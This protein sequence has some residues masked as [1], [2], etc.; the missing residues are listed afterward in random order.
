MLSKNLVE[1]K[2]IQKSYFNK[3]IIKGID[4]NLEEG[5]FYCLLGRNGTGK[6]TL[7]RIIAGIE[8]PQ[9]GEGHVLG[10][11]LYEFG[12]NIYKNFAY[13]S[14]DMEFNIG[15]LSLFFEVYK[16]CY[17]Q[18]DLRLLYQ[19]LKEFQIN[20]EKKFMDLSR[21]QKMQVVLL[22]SICR[23]P[24][25]ILIDEATAVLDLF[26]KEKLLHD[27][28]ELVKRNGATVLIVSN[29]VGE[30]EGYV[31]EAI[32]LDNGQIKKI[33]KI[34]ELKNGCYKIRVPLKKLKS[35]FD[36]GYVPV[37]RDGEGMATFLIPKTKLPGEHLKLIDQYKDHRSVSLEEFYLLICQENKS[38]E[39]VA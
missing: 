32:F 15:S 28:H 29:V 17:P 30:L 36:L 31:D 37:K 9:E 8:V 21:G 23:Q 3:K 38:E 19:K 5:K 7:S 6:S 16:E 25:F 1:L 26:A 20:P 14:E 4:L 22:A 35:F 24:K 12:E 2:N 18:L 39:K 13:I 11:P 27:L 10:D 33:E 34:S